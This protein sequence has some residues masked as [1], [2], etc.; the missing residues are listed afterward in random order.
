MAKRKN[1]QLLERKL[2]NPPTKLLAILRDQ[3]AMCEKVAPTC[4]NF[5]DRIWSKVVYPV[6]RHLGFDVVSTAESRKAVRE[7]VELAVDYFGDRWWRKEVKQSDFTKEELESLQFN[8]TAWDKDNATRFS[9]SWLAEYAD[10]NRM[11]RDKTHPKRELVWYK[12]FTSALFLAGL[13]SRWDDLARICS[14]F[15]ATVE[16][17]YQAGQLE[18]EYMQLF[19]CIAGSLSHQPMTGL[20]RLVSKVKKC[21]T[22][23]PKLLCAAWEAANAADQAAF[24]KA[25]PQTVNHFLSKPDDSLNAEDWIAID[26]SSIWLIA[27]HRGLT[28]PPLSEKEIAAVVTRESAGLAK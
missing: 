1:Y 2:M 14:W 26:Q 28:F 27:E 12:A 11:G 20:D 25:F 8:P 7:G 18:D 19:V 23:R 5:S 16:P 13:A 21:R 4:A 17:E 22:K 6:L 10:Y 15:D 24:N 3:E 9:A